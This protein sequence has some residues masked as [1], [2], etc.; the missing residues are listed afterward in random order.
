MAVIKN[1][2]DLEISEELLDKY[3]DN[4]IG[5]FYKIL[6]IFEGRDIK[7]KEVVYTKEEAYLQ[8]QKYISNF[9]VE[10]CGGYYLFNDSMYF[11][12]LL[13]ILEGMY[14]ISQEDH[15]KLK[16]LVFNCISICKKLKTKG[17]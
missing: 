9:I 11:L 8:F 7:N 3:Y 12:K 14:V 1:K 6:P 17:E 4:L 2:Y 16:S 15:C 5:D 13:N 10:I